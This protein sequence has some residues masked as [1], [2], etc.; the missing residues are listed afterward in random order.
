MRYAAGFATRWGARMASPDVPTRSEQAEQDALLRIQRI[1]ELERRSNFIQWFLIALMVVVIAV[2]VVGAF[3]LARINEEIGGVAIDNARVIGESALCPGEKL[4]IV[5][6]FHADGAGKLIE[7]GT[8]WRE[9]PPKTVVYS[10][11]GP[12]LLEGTIDQEVTL[13]WQVPTTYVNP[14]TGIDEPLPPGVYRRLFSVSSASR[15]AVFA[16][17]GVDFSIREDCE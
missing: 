9:S 15:S 1:D 10:V 7:D 11:S 3:W 6:D 4:I 14:A 13:A 16:M 8:A 17:A 2:P 12:F 5:Y